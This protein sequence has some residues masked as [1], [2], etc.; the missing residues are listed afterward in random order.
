MLERDHLFALSVFFGIPLIDRTHTLKGPIKTVI[1][2]PV[3]TNAEVMAFTKTLD[4][5]M[6]ERAHALL[7]MAKAQGK[8]LQV[9]WSGGIDSTALL[10]ALM[11]AC[12]EEDRKSVV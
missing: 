10:I 9:M 8:V 1:M 4:E 3:P 6:L 5:V 7:E 11:R 2:D 12:S